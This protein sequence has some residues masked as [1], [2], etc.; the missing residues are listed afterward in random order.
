MNTVYD[1]STK[2]N[3]KISYCSFIQTT[4]LNLDLSPSS[5]GTY[6]LRDIILLA[7]QEDNFEDIN[8]KHL[9][10]KLAKNKNILPSTIKTNIDYSFRI[11]N[12]SKAKD[13]FE[14]IFNIKYDEY[15]LTAKTLTNLIYSLIYMQINS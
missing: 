15:Y 10:N 6:Y 7:I 11:K 1:V 9:Q 12:T 3:G 13:N 8:L 14:T 5:K 2:D 4:L